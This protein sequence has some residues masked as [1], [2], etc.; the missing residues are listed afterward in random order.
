MGQSYAVSDELIECIHDLL[1]YEG[2]ILELGSGL[3][4]TGRLIEH[5][6]MIS[7]EH[8]EKY[9]GWYESTYIHAPIEPFRKACAMFPRDTGWY[10][11]EILRRELPKHSY[12]LILVDGPP[13]TIGRGGFYKWKELFNLEVPIVI[14][15]IHR[16]REI[17]LIRKMGQHLGRP[18]MVYPWGRHHFGVI[19]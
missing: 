19:V 2:T 14:D 16:E 10:S 13:N 8:D 12:D 15:D 5:Y 3:G 7:V 17:H 18:F 4:S 9:L 6:D 1:H 11:R